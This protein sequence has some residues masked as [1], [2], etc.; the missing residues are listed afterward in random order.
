MNNISKCSM[1]GMWLIGEEESHSPGSPYRGADGINWE[2]FLPT[3]AI[4]SDETLQET[5]RKDSNDDLPI[6]KYGPRY[7]WNQYIKRD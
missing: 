2:L 5:N 6:P 3:N 7:D 1:C 4:P